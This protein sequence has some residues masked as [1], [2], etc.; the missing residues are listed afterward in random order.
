MTS[1]VGVV[2]LVSDRITLAPLTLYE[3]GTWLLVMGIALEIQQVLVKAGG[4]TSAHKICCGGSQS[5]QTQN[6]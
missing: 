2:I 4:Q 5:L 1:Q 3:A 6:R